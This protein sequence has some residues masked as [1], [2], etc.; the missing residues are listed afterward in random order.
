VQAGRGEGAIALVGGCACSGFVK[1]TPL[2]PLAI[3][4]HRL[5]AWCGASRGGKAA[6]KKGPCRK[7]KPMLTCRLT[8]GLYDHDPPQNPRH[9]TSIPGTAPDNF[10]RGL[11]GG[12]FVKNVTSPSRQQSLLSRASTSLCRGHFLQIDAYREELWLVYPRVRDREKGLYPASHLGSLVPDH[13]ATCIRSTISRVTSIATR[14][15][16]EP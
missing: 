12:N 14:E 11:I 8:T 4:R 7:W 16:R 15:S 3:T 6:V 2:S 9:R 5:P 10:G 1:Q 13:R